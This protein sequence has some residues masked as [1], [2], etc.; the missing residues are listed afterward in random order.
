MAVSVFSAVP[1][2][3]WAVMSWARAVVRALVVSASDVSPT[4]S[5]PGHSSV[6]STPPPTVVSWR[7]HRCS[8][9]FTWPSRM[10]SFSTWWRP[11]SANAGP[12]LPPR[13]MAVAAAAPTNRARLTG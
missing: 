11:S 3:S 8:V 6:S 5:G 13:M 10:F 2:T 4:P 7:N 12:T 1:S 9:L